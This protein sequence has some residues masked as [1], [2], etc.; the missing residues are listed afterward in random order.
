M[1]IMPSWP[2]MMGIASLMAS[3]ADLKIGL[4]IVDMTKNKKTRSAKPNGQKKI[5]YRLLLRVINHH[6]A[7][8]NQLVF[9]PVSAVQ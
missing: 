4:K 3:R 2:A 9:A 8:V 5:C 1:S 7:A 6:F